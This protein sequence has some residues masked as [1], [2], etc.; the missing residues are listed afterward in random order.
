M[1]VQCESCK[2]YF[3]MPGISDEQDIAPS[4]EKLCNACLLAH[5]EKLVYG[6]SSR[7]EN[8]NRVVENVPQEAA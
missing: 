1:L 7:M 2:N 3:E 4:R 5:I 8:R 6:Q